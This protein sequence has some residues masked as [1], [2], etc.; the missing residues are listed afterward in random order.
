MDPIEAMKKEMLRRKLSY[1]TIHTYIFYVKKF[2]LFTKDKPIKQISKKD[3]NEFLNQ[4]MEN[5][6]PWSKF[7]DEIAGSTLNVALNSIKFLME[8]ILRKS[9]RLNIKYSK[10]PKTLPTCLTKEEVLIFINTITNPKHKLLISL[11]YGAGLR[12]SEVTKLKPQDLDITTNVGWV[13][14]GKGNK[15]RPFIIPKCLTEE[16]KA[17]LQQNPIY[18]FPGRKSHLTTRSVEMIINNIT[19]KLKWKKNIHPHTFRHSFATH[20]LEQGSDITSVQSLLGHNEA[21]TTLTYLHIVK[22]ELIKIKS[23]LD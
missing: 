16:L 1:K 4:F 19:K 21:R 2:L 9:M 18:I 10:T 13:R 6:L 11:M 12:V 8:E 17:I 20:L 14:H 3:C 5:K 22:P 23:P 15:D 7:N